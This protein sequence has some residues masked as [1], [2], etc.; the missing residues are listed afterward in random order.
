MISRGEN[1]IFNGMFENINNGFSVVS[2]DYPNDLIINFQE[3]FAYTS[4]LLYHNKRIYRTFS[5][6][7][8]A[9]NKPLSIRE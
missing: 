6:H 8:Y 5:S 2:E 4:A 7:E 9:K 3:H 1:K